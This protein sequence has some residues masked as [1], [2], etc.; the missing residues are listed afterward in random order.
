M[1][2]GDVTLRPYSPTRVNCGEARRDCRRWR[3][4]WPVAPKMSALLGD[5]AKGNNKFLVNKSFE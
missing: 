3:P 1:S 5:N 2:L 4:V